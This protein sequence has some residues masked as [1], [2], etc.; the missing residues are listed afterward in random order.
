MK[1]SNIG[2]WAQNDLTIGSGN[3]VV[4][5]Y[6]STGNYSNCVIIGESNESKN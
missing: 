1:T 2:P 6:A 3:L 4:G 5:L